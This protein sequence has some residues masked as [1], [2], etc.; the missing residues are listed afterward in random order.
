MPDGAA[1]VKYEGKRGIVWR[2]KYRDAD[3]HQVME[4]LGKASDGWTRRKAQHELRARLTD[5]TRDGYRRPQT[6]TFRPFAEQWRDE[7][8]H[9]RG[10]KASTKEGYAGIIDRHLVPALGSLRLAD[11]DV[12]RVEQYITLKR[13]D[14][15][16]AGTVNRHLN[17]LSLVM[18]TAL[19][20]SLVRVNPVALVE[21]PRER[22]TEW[23][24]LS[25]LEVAA[26]ERA[27]SAMVEAEESDVER[28]W[29]ATCRIVFLTVQEAGLRR[30]EVL[31]LRWR[32]AAL[33]DPEV[34][35]LRI[36]E[37]FVRGRV[38]TP[39][40]EASTRTVPISSALAD[41]LF[42]HRS[43]SAFQGD[44]ERMFVSPYR[45]S[46]L[47]PK[48]Y[49]TTFRTALAGAGILDYV[50]PFHDGRH[51]AITNAARHGRGEMALM[52][53]AGHSDS[54]TTRRYTHLA[55]VMFAEEAE[56]MGGGALW[57]SS[58]KSGR[59]TEDL[60]P[61]EATESLAMQA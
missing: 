7:Y 38:D 18:T 44:D 39:K 58:R 28:R 19:R 8:P 29:I 55:G 16:G 17:V 27:F 59:K 23:R 32:H 31:G 33:A 48:R 22:L 50:R 61:S 51:S 10:L 34:P 36:V 57:G 3:G 1:V 26:V 14:G 56:R 43:G 12:P 25:P 15:S 5:V 46:P 42:Q 21:R 45:G 40:S 35:H 30:G 11:I 52:T 60:S 41:E 49:A 6:T 53:I 24:I 54:R 2:V 37:T 20:R 9:A 13:K 4:T 47:N